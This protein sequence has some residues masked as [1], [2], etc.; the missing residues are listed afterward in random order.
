MD[1]K[2]W[3]SSLISG[4]RMKKAVSELVT[5]SIIEV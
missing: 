5:K 4:K 1:A 2:F 3:H